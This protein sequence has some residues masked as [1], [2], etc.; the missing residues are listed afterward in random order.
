M[1]NH[2]LSNPVSAFILYF[3]FLI[4]L[5]NSNSVEA[6]S[7]PC[8]FCEITQNKKQESRVVYRD[9]TIVAF[10]DYAPINPGHVLVVP[11]MHATDLLDMPDSTVRDML[12]VAKKIAAAIKKTDIKAEGIRFLSNAGESAGQD[13]FHAHLHIIPRFTGDNFNAKKV[14][15]PANELDE[16]ARKIREALAR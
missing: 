3:L 6:Q 2:K 1:K 8:V 15:A 5:L 14:K 9:K 11:L 7:K 4:G 16:A 13:M 12:S 10:M